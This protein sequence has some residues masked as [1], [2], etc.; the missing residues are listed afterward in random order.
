MVAGLALSCCLGLV[1][2][3]DSGNGSELAQPAKADVASIEELRPAVDAFCGNCHASPPPESFP[4]DAWF[5]E[6]EQGYRF[7]QESG[8]TDLK[9]PP[10]PD[11]VAYFRSQA[12]KVLTIPSHATSLTAADRFR[13]MS[14]P[15]QRSAPAISFLGL[16]QRRGTGAVWLCD[17]QSGVV[18]SVTCSPSS[19]TISDVTRIAN[20]AH[21]VECD[22][23]QDGLSD[24]IVAELGSLAPGDHHNGRV[25]WLP[26]A[27]EPGAPRTDAR[28][29]L[30]QVG[31][32]ADVRPADFDGDGDMDLVVAEFGWRKT[33]QILLLLQTN[34][35]PEGPEFS[36][37]VV[38]QRHGTIHV[39][40]ADLNRDGRPDFFALISQEHEV[41]EAFLNLG[42]GQFE[43]RRIFTAPDPAFGFS[44]IELVDLDLDGD[45]DVVATNGDTLDSHYLK[46]SHGILWLKNNGEFPFEARRL[47]DLPGAMR[48]V[49][50]DL[51]GDG[52][53]D[54]IAAAF[55]PATLHS[56]QPNT[57]HETLIWLKQGQSGDFE[58]HT[59]ETGHAGHM[60]VIATDLDA[61]GDIDLAVP[62]YAEQ[63]T[64]N[65]E[66]LTIWWNE[67]RIMPAD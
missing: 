28:V 40:V 44:G 39:P 24:L 37:R 54:I 48:A 42:D 34:R 30:D 66:P 59:L 52:L 20:P 36:R 3:R 1:S 32:V 19:P 18:S 47:A 5:T 23:D 64:I 58:R 38:D 46:P 67:M 2:C 65:L 16:A 25:Y 27:G 60:T 41:I 51:D 8:R 57:I 10:M 43:K 62:N 29:L 49:S 7:Y 45:L 50:A 61:D 26:G 11:V 31:R 56:Q 12:P 22:L 6:T 63:R 9:P 17:M 21:L 53:M 33:G 4:R 15:K 55:L 13:K 14:L 35:G